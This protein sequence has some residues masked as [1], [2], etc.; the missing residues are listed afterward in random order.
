MPEVTPRPPWRDMDLAT[1]ER[2]YSPSSALDGPLDPFIQAYVD[3]SRQAYDLCPGMV[4]LAYG[5]KATQTIDIVAPEAPGAVPLLIF[6]HGGYWQELSKREA[7]FPAPDALA[8]G[9]AFAT[10]DYSLCPDV[11]L[12]D[13]VEC[14]AAVTRLITEAGALGVDPG[15]VVLSG[16][17]AGAHLAAMVCARLPAALRPAGVVLLSGVFD[18]EPLIDTYINAAVGLD[19]SAARRNSPVRLDL[20]GFPPALVAWGQQETDEFKRQ[21][22][23]FAGLLQAEGRRACVLDVAGRN[24]FDI[25]ED[26]ANDTELG[27]AMAALVAT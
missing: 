3:K 16:S 18:L 6:I 9:M 15:R 13:I 26:I 24:H 21:S 7:F 22:R 11:T 19:L 27:R 25:V 23:H 20:R 5:D 14:C 2:A 17:S 4:T 12:D 8:R 1:L 10:V